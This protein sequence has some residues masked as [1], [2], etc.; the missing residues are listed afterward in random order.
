M[1]KYEAKVIP[2]LK[3]NIRPHD[4]ADRLVLFNP[5]GTGY[6]VCLN[7]ADWIDESG[8]LKATK[9]IHIEPDHE[10]PLNRPEFEWLK[11]SIDK[12][13]IPTMYRVRA[14]KLRGVSSFGFVIKAPEEANIGEDWFEK[15]GMS[16][17]NPQEPSGENSQ[18]V[19]AP[20]RDFSKY[21]VENS[22]KYLDA[23][24][25]KQV[26]C[27]L[28]IHGQNCRVSYQD[29]QVYVGSR[30]FWKTDV[31]G[32]DFWN[33]YR[34]EPGLELLVKENPQ[35]CVYGESYGNNANF[36]EDAQPGE[37][38][39]RAFDIFDM[40]RNVWLDNADFELICQKYKVS[41]CP[42]VYQG[43]F[44][45]ARFKEIVEL[46]SPLCKKQ[47]SEG[48]VICTEKEEW[49]PKLGRCKAKIV[50]CRYLEKS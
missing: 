10:V 9:V 4:G 42:V 33:S 20:Q 13:I 22:L 36:R 3:E 12:V 47:P 11:A 46:D 6:N 8:E 43:L 44:D 26:V 29:G 21:D 25:G 50:S 15:L 38:K 14:K 5:P 30:S 24:E 2:F 31:P 40:A 39:F 27:R 28:K 17:Y 48:M 23:F 37:R 19:K 1:S 45:L 41:T 32:S 7:K 16:H 35:Y 34:S 49:H 18:C